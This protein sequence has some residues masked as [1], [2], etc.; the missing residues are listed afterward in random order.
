MQHNFDTKGIVNEELQNLMGRLNDQSARKEDYI[1][2][3]MDV[4]SLNTDYG[5]NYFS[6]A[7]EDNPRSFLRVEGSGGLQ[8]K[9]FGINDHALG[10]IAT[11]LDIPVRALRN[12]RQN[13]KAQEHMDSVVTELFQARSD[14]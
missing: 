8:T 10:Q 5:G 13:Q 14:K 7:S 2:P 9:E 4:L 12:I 3:S 1:I 6:D 11:D